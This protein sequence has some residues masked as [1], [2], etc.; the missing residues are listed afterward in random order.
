MPNNQTLRRTPSPAMPQGGGNPAL[1]M[2]GLQAPDRINPLFFGV[3]PR[4]LWD[5][6]KDFFTYST[7]F[8]PI[9]AATAVTN[10]IA[11]QAD[12]YF[13]I[14]AGVRTITDGA[15]GLVFA[16]NGP[17]TIAVNDQS[18]GRDFQNQAMG[19]DNLLGTAQLPAFWPFPK[20][21]QPSSTLAVSLTNFDPALGFNVRISFLGFKIFAGF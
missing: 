7:D 19:I 12:S 14:V 4:D 18:S 20:L 21:I 8:L 17:M 13:L 3:L 15:T 2:A 5:K 11:I 9:A 16:A 6:S 1:T 10:N